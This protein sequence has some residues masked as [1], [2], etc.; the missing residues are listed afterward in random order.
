[1][2]RVTQIRTLIALIGGLFSILAFAKP[3]ELDEISRKEVAERIAPVS[4]VCKEGEE[5][6]AN[7][8]AVA[9]TSSGPRSGEQIFNQ[10]CTACHT[11]GLLGAP[12]KDDK[13][14]WETKLSAAGDFSKLL[15]N[16]I[17]G[18]GSMPPKGT[19]MDCSDEEMSNAIEFMSGL[20]P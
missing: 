12:K 9:S 14:A 20:K 3:V 7:A 11:T 2:S 4:S 6:A 13:A 10:F 1:M 5:C 16:A 17:S 19:C 15:G 8:S 18:I